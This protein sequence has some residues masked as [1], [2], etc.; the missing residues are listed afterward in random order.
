MEVNARALL[1]A[2]VGITSEAEDAEDTAAEAARQYRRELT[3][4]KII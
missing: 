3:G 1:L 4:L 2:H